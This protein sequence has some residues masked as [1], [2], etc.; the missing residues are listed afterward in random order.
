[1][2]TLL[3][4][5]PAA[6]RTQ[7]TQTTQTTKRLVLQRHIERLS[8]RLQ[9]LEVI[10]LRY[11][12]GRWG[13]V[14]GGLL[15]MW[16]SARIWGTGVG[17]GVLTVVVIAF[18][19]VAS[20]HRRVNS[21]INRHWLW[22][23]IKA[24]HL[25]RMARDWAHMPLAPDM[26][27]EEGHPFATDLNLTGSRSVLH[28]IDTAMSR[29]GSDRLRTWL[30][31]PDLTPDHIR[32]RQDI[33][34]E[35]IPLSMFRDRLALHG[36]ETARK[37]EE[38]WEGESILAWLERESRS[39]SLRP[40]AIVLAVLAALNIALYTLHTLAVVP[41]LWP[42]SLLL[43]LGLYTAQSRAVRD[44]FDD[45]YRLE[46]TLRRFQAVLVYLETYRYDLTPRLAQLCAPFWRGEPRPSAIL[47]Q[48]VRIAG[49]ASAQKANI[50]G[51]VLNLLVPWDIW[52][53]Y[54]FHLCKEAVQP[55]LPLWIETWH[56]L[57][58]LNALAH[59][60]ALNPGYRFAE[61]Q[62]PED[63]R[64]V[65]DACA[66]GHPLLPEESR[67]CNDV[68]FHMLGELLMITGSNMSG[69]STFLRTLGVNLCLAY[70]GAPV[71]ASQ[72]H[73]L[74][75]RVF[76]CIN[77]S[78]SVTDGI[79]YFYA[80]VRRLKALLVALQSDQPDPVFF[81]IDEIF[82]GTNNRERLLGSR[83]YVQALTGG[84]GVGAVSTHDLDLVTLVDAVPTIR[85]SHFR[86][87]V[88]DGRMVFDYHL[89]SGP[90]PTTN[91]LT[92]MEMEGLPVPASPGNLAQTS[93]G[94]NSAPGHTS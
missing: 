25:A 87:T 3:T 73:T 38:K 75:F 68:T 69:K 85:N 94:P 86:E 2:D 92:I 51:V 19:V 34:R 56:E 6:L 43:Y 42:F 37:S 64:P 5:S 1:L 53:A 48:I 55:Q 89:R 24:T 79:S 62:A 27:P 80:E 39:A 30:L 54:R 26:P 77:V 40:W 78:D 9:T 49:A 61:F 4:Q 28:L 81:L 59:F 58:A 20:Y 11:T 84:H 83:A 23:E 46:Q 91:A 10:S 45:A 21:S 15:L 33:V 47:K 31:Y 16:L 72:F 44:L 88:A 66:L 22:R 63:D 8:R 17:W 60:G 71:N 70:A 52:V 18:A 12:R 29:G 90:C 13:V 7:T 41:L 93:G 67:V 74:P 35:L 50:F 82:R 32:Q 14:L 76:T 36:A 65:L 57:E